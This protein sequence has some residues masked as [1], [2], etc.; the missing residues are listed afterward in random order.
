MPQLPQKRSEPAMLPHE[1]Q[2]TLLTGG[3]L[4]EWTMASAYACFSTPVKGARYTLLKWYDICRLLRSRGGST[5]RTRY[6]TGVF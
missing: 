3:Q 6:I 2:R 5:D 4:E 1:G